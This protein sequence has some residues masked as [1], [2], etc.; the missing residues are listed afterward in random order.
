MKIA[1]KYALIPTATLILWIVIVRLVMGVGPDSKLNIVG[2]VLFSIAQII[3]I[4]LGIRRRKREQGNLS[5]G[6]GMQTGFLISLIYAM[7]ACSFFVL[8]L[9]VGP[10]LLP[11]EPGAE[12]RPMWQT[13]VM[14]FAGLF[15][16]TIFLGLIYSIVISL[17]M[18]R[19]SG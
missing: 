17:I 13:A 10:N 18:R 9:L 15:F 12:S 3:A 1:L 4:C 7:L 5:F 8:E 6:Q 19:R 14:A 16:G 11:V 2:P